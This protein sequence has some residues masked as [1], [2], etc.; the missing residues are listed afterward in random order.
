MFNNIDVQGNP[1]AAITNALVN[2]GW[3]YVY[4]CHIL[5]HEEMDMMRP[6]S[7]AL[8]PAKPIDVT[9]TTTTSP[10]RVEVHWTDNSI[11]ETSFLVQRSSDGTIWEDV[12]TSGTPLDQPN[13]KGDAR[14]LVDSSSNVNR[15]Y[16]Y[17]VQALN[18]VGYGGAFPS[19]TARST[20]DAVGFNPPS[21]PTSLGAAVAATSPAVALTWTDTAGNEDGFVIER[22]TDGVSFSELAT[23]PARNGTGSVTY[24]DT[25]VAVDG[26]YTYRVRAFNL[27]GSSPWSNE[28]SVQVVAPAAPT[29]N[30][31]TAARAGNREKITANW[32][33]VQGET[34]YT[35]QWS[36]TSDFATVAGSGT[37]GADV[38]TYTSA[39]I[40]RQVWFVR[41]R[42]ENGAGPSAWSNVIQVAAAA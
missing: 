41:V 38:L 13:T 2:F 35:V 7:V 20:S 26:S 30:S 42:A 6:V 10:A 3:E 34:A 8:P 31:V 28:A 24:D 21:A 19:L 18:T 23:V 1:T 4:H 9:T 25:T 33:D 39:N 40:T 12:G 5:S 17:R 15:V 36:A 27:A 32:S 16:L 29:L 11:T 22:A 37:V 14:S